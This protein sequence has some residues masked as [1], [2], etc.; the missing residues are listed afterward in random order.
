MDLLNKLKD[1]A[2]SVADTVGDAV[3]TVKE[4]AKDA[5]LSALL[6]FAEKELKEKLDREIEIVVDDVPDN[7][8]EWVMKCGINS[9]LN[10]STWDFLEDSDSNKP[11]L[12]L[13]KIRD[14]KKITM[15]VNPECDDEDNHVV[16]NVD[17][18]ADETEFTITWFPRAK[19]W[20]SENTWMVD[21]PKS[22][23]VIRDE[24]VFGLKLYQLPGVCFYKS[25]FLEMDD[26]DGEHLAKKYKRWFQFRHWVIF[27]YARAR[28]GWN[29][30]WTKTPPP[31][32]DGSLF[33][34]DSVLSVPSL[35]ELKMPSVSLPSLPDVEMP[36]LPDMP[37]MP[38]MP[39]ISAPSLSAP[40]LSAPSL[41]APDLSNLSAPSIPEKPQRPKNK[42]GC[43]G[44]IELN[45]LK[46]KAKGS[47]LIF[48]NATI[49]HFW[50]DGHHIKDEKKDRQR[51]EL[52]TTD[53]EQ[54]ASWVESLLESGVEEGEDGGCCTIA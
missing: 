10:D 44:L 29:Y 18:K 13:W 54:A 27:W 53:E 49:T 19:D 15:A 43:H 1:T 42:W 40:S 23:W 16:C 8:K 2:E 34:L 37:D 39:S 26:T 31:N 35:P 52:E 51:L 33:S 22:W 41:S 12:D 4:A 30:Q 50:Q 28:H 45:G 11:K 7:W 5:G 17:W 9:I 14:I 6:V 47:K 38:D 32:A 36:S 24:I 48:S 46:I 21:G 3:D 20:K 25:D